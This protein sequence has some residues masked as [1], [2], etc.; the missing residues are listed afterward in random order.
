MRLECKCKHAKSSHNIYHL[1]KNKRIV[2]YK[3][4]RCNFPNC[5]CKKYTFKKKTYPHY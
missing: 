1:K 4:G 3:K 2:N 5:K